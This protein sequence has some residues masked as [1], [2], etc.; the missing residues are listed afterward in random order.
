MILGSDEHANLIQDLVQEFEVKFTP[1]GATQNSI[2]VA[3]WVLQKRGSTTF[4]GSIGTDAFGQLMKEAV[5]CEGVAEEYLEVCDKPTGT[6]AVLITGNGLNRSLVSFPG[7]ARALQ[8]KDLPWHV[9]RKASV[10]YVAGFT[11]KSAFEAVLQLA[12]HAQQAHKTFCL[13]LSAEYI[14]S[15]QVDKLKQVLPLV[16][17]LFGNEGELLALAAAMA[18]VSFARRSSK[19]APCS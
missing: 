4:I 16:D 10:L 1:G 6:C 18:W 8:A 14:A 7:A 15:S 12:Q 2:R 17:I 13:N 3:Q 19:I 11:L 9:V 5:R